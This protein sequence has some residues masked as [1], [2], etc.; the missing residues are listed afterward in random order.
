M[1]R[2][3][4]I[5]SL[6]HGGDGIGRI[7]GQVCFVPY[8]LPGDALRVCIER[9]AKGVLWAR[10]VGIETPS[11]VRQSVDCPAYERCGGCAWLHFSYPAQAEW[12]CRIVGDSLKRIAKLDT[13]V[14]WVEDAS[15]RLGYRTRAEFHGTREG[16]GFHA[17][18]S[19]DVVPIASCPLCH[20]NLNAALRRLEGIRGHGDIEIAV[21]PEGDDVLVWSRRPSNA[22]LKAFTQCD[23]DERSA[24]RA[25]F[26]FDGAPIVNGTFSQASLLLNRTLRRVVRAQIGDPANLIELYCGNGNLTLDLPRGVRV[27]GYD[28][29]G[30]AVRA[31]AALRADAYQAADERSFCDALAAEPWDVVLLDPPR[32]GAKA[33]AP[34]LAACHAARMVYVSCDPAT[35]ARDLAIICAAKWRLVRTVAVD[36]FPHT[37]HVETVC[38]LEHR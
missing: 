11:P 9:K 34:S 27:R 2:H 18:Q 14:E 3:I 5:T 24:D 1:E 36:L 17:R 29:N 4:E 22:L 32:T 15:L 30:A 8:G 38:L 12:K 33:I 35:L 13:E 23:F 6:A 31:A 28:H 16:W 7:E 20:P 25:M 37:A 26:L 19:H 10:I 21:N